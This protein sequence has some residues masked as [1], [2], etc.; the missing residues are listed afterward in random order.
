[1]AGCRVGVFLLLG[2]LWTA[3]GVK[4][5]LVSPDLELPKAVGGFEVIIRGKTVLFT[6]PAPDGKHREEISG[7]RLFYEDLL[8]DR[9]RGCNCRRFHDLAFVDPVSSEIVDGRLQLKLDIDPVWMGKLYSYLV[10]P[11]SRKGFAGAESEEE[12]V[13]WEPSPPPPSSLTAVPGDR[14]ATLQWKSPPGESV[15]Y[16]VYRRSGKAAFP[17]HPVNAVPLGKPHFEEGGLRNGTTYHYAV[18][19]IAAGGPPWIESVSSP[20]VSVIPLDRKA[21]ASPIGIEAIAG[22]GRVRLFWEENKETDLAGYR[23]YRRTKKEK[24]ARFIGE[25]KTPGTAFTDSSVSAGVRYEYSVTAFDH[26]PEP[27]ESAP[28]R[29]VT[30]VAQ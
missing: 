30:V 16:L 13:L 1:M 7:Y 17:L 27:N 8:A 21:P 20:E 12:V 28:S 19:S 2:L 23:V 25:V 6:W 14:T 3:C 10:V 24:N 18:R 26:A 15:R 11:V 4:T 22:P 9:Q 29:K 5:P